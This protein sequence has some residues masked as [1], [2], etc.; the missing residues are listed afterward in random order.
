MRVLDTGELIEPDFHDGYLV[1]IDLPEKDRATIT[2]REERGIQ[3]ELGLE[4]VLTIMADELRSVNIIFS[5]HLYDSLQMR[6]ED[7][8]EAF[9]FNKANPSDAQ[10]VSNFMKSLSNEE[11]KMV[12][13]APSLG[14][15]LHAICKK[16][17]IRK[18]TD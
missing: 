4:G 18:L 13:V 6:S 14:C 7:V 17:E 11:W 1:R 12:I 15:L 3:Y 2:L 9:G 5:V 16:V 10:H 8:Y